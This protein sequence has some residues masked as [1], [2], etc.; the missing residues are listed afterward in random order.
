MN[1]KYL[2]LAAACLGSVT[3]QAKDSIYKKRVDRPQQERCKR[4][5]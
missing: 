3:I 1:V 5:L 4:R 2:L